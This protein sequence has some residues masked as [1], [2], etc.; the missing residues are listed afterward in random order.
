MSDMHKLA[1][2]WDRTA[3]N[4]KAMRD[5]AAFDYREGHIDGQIAAIE[6]CASELR[7]AMGIQCLWTCGDPDMNLWNTCGSEWYFEHGGPDENGMKFC[8]FCGKPLRQNPA[9]ENHE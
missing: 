1:D 8:P 7:S 5:L 2:K 6:Q 3:S 9:K 4:I